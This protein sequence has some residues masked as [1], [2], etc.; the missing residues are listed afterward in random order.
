MFLATDAPHAKFDGRHIVLTVPS[1]NTN[2]QIAMTPHEALS[3][4]HS[5][6]L[7]ASEV[8]RVANRDT[9]QIAEIVALPRRSVA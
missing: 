6:L 1:G 9:E 2:E 5:L 4:G 8:L 7:V 3:M